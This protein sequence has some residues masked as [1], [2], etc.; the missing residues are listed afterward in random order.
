M[1]K[2]FLFCAAVILQVLPLQVNAQQNKSSEILSGFI[3]RI[4][5]L[6]A[7]EIQFT[8]TVNG[9]TIEGMVESQKE[10]FRLING[11]MEIYCNGMTKW[12][13]NI[14][15]KEIT[16]VDNDPSTT[17]LT[18]NP[19][20]FFNSLEKS[21]SYDQKAKSHITKANP[22]SPVS[23]LTDVNIPQS[24]INK[25]LWII[26][27]RPKNKHL[28]YSSITLGIEKGTLNP[29]LVAYNL[30]EGASHIIY[31]TKFVERKPWAQDYFIFPETKLK[32][33]HVTDLR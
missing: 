9:D 14:D 33:M 16:I 2:F 22:S 12:I 31:I 25:Q 26:D 32:G 23:S 3:S 20:A 15:N 27:L 21:Y 30:K 1:N 7:A 18:E 5:S 4:E 11:Q 17:D 8:M 6:R 24:L 13:Y 10:S 19:M 28:S 29:V